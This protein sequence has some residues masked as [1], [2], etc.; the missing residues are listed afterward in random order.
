MRIA[1][2][3]VNSLRSRIE[4]VE[5][6]LQRHDDRR[7]RRPGDQGPRGPAAPDGAAGGRLR[8]G[9]RRATNQWNG[10]ALISRVGLDDVTDRL[11]PDAGVGRAAGARVARDR[12][13]LWRRT[14]HV[15]ST[16]PTA[17]SPTTPTTSTSSTGWRGC[18]RP[19]TVARRHPDGAGRRLEH[20]PDRRRRLRPGAVQEQHPR[21]A[22]RAGCLPGV[23]RRR[24]CRGHPPLRARLH[25]LGLLP[26]ALRA[27]PWPQDRLRAGDTGAGRAGDRRDASTATSGPA[28]APPTTRR[29]SSTSPTARARPA[30]QDIENFTWSTQVSVWLP[31]ASW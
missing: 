22:A 26:P 16:S 18:A 21:H 12:G 2:W 28:R 6:F 4:R 20:L 10:V 25:L 11:R 1:T 29:C 27:R 3:N 15:A 8:R 14:D 24:V 19:P 17:A 5:A 7:A 9:R 13:D 30:Q 23:P 31:S